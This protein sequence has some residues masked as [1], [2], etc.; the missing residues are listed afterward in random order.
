MKHVLVLCV[1]LFLVACTNAPSPTPVPTNPPASTV[2]ATKPL[3]PTS[4]SLPT[5]APGTSVLVEYTRTGGIAGFND[6]LTVYPDGKAKLSRKN[7]SFDL[8]LSAEQLKQ[9]L[10]VFQIAGFVNLKEAPPKLLVPDELSYVMT[11]QGK[12][13]RT[14]DTQ[15]PAE[16]QPV[17]TLLNALVDSKK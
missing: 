11:F 14:S 1:I 9:M 16:L 15:M 4:T 6:R 12:T 17:I 5:L 2:P 7:G 13:F 3:A 10:A 8:V